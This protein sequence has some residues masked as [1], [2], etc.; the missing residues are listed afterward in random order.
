M[1]NSMILV[2]LVLMTTGTLSFQ[3]ISDQI[4]VPRYTQNRVPVNYEIFSEQELI[5]LR[6]PAVSFEISA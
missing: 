1:K 2:L 3:A 6:F 5:S 4:G